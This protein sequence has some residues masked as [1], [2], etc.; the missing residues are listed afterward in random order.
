[1]E[2]ANPYHLI[3]L[4]EVRTPNRPVLAIVHLVRRVG[5]RRK[6]TSGEDKKKS[7]PGPLFLYYLLHHFR[8]I[9]CDMPKMGEIY[10]ISPFEYIFLRMRKP[11]KKV[12]HYKT[13]IIHSSEH[14]LLSLYIFIFFCI[15]EHFME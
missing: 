6:G 14:L 4:P 12:D 5:E 2:L 11:L 9:A 8:D 7:G 13:K 1:M 10:Q 3:P 15:L